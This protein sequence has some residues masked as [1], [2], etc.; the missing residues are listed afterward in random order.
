MS[1][2][3]LVV[4]QKYSLPHILDDRNCKGLMRMKRNGERWHTTVETTIIIGIATRRTEEIIQKAR[5]SRTVS[6]SVEKD[7]ALMIEWLP[8]SGRCSTAST[9]GE[10]IFASLAVLREGMDVANELASTIV[11]TAKVAVPRSA[12]ACKPSQTNKNHCLLK[13]RHINNTELRNFT[14]IT[15]SIQ[16]Q[17][18]QRNNRF[19]V[20]EWNM[21]S[22]SQLWNEKSKQKDW[23]SP[24][25]LA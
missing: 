2:I 24:S 12:A 11:C 14:Y 6:K 4:R 5:E 16:D 7:T 13:L 17:S 25:A 9:L 15:I 8:V 18:E 20:R 21:L 19:K 22:T 1:K 3:S 23:L 10:E